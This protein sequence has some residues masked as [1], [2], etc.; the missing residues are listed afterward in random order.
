MANK[1]QFNIK[2][3]HYAVLTNGTYGTPVHIPGAVSLSVDPTGD[4]STFYADG[5]EYYKSYNNSGYEGS[6]EMALI[7][8]QF[9][10][11]I[12]GDTLDTKNVLIENAFAPTVYFAL[13]FQV[14]GDDASTYF[15]FYN[16]TASRPSM[17]A[18]TNEESK[19]PDTQTLDWSCA[20]DS[21]GIVRAKTT[22]TTASTDINSWFTA[23]YQQTNG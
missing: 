14:D 3:V 23:V 11:D 4:D 2:N 15:W 6:L 10:Q 18:N 1:V 5:I 16:C 20:P 21:T 19:E 17:E 13:G 9:R 12:L 8:D 22:A 7:P